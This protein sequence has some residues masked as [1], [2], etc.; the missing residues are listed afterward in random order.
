[1]YNTSVY[2]IET[3]AGKKNP[4]IFQHNTFSLEIQHQLK[5]FVVLYTPLHS[6]DNAVK[7]QKV[8]PKKPET[9]KEQTKRALPENTDRARKFVLWPTVLKNAS[10]TW[11]RKK[12]KTTQTTDKERLKSNLMIKEVLPRLKTSTWKQKAMDEKK[13]YYWSPT[14]EPSVITTLHWVVISKHHIFHDWFKLS[15]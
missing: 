4:Q 7:W 2:K 3:K 10:L 9:C 6:A 11:V 14:F 12:T 15:L 8:C 5:K 1:M 13:K